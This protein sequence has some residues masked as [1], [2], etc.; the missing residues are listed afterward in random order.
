MRAFIACDISHAGIKDVLEEIKKTGAN[1]KLV[2]PENTHLTLKF[3]GEIQEEMA[4]KIG[5]AMKRS[6]LGTSSMEARLSGVGVFPSLKYIKVVW[7]GVECPELEKLQRKLDTALSELGFKKEGGF[8]PHLTIGRVRSAKNKQRLL[9][10]VEKLKG[11]EIGTVEIDAI[12]LKKSKLTP[13]GPIYTDTEEVK[14]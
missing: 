8:K 1:I 7:I 14:L 13:T 11:R 4:E 9:E 2:E 3:L 6:C 12:K 5:E 10:A